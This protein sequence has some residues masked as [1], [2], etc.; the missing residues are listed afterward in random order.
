MTE[1]QDGPPID[2][3]FPLKDRFR[4][5]FI[6]ALLAFVGI[7][8][9]II[10]FTARHAVE[11]IYL[12]LA[13]RRAQSIVRSIEE[14][15]NATWA[16]LMAGRSLT[17]LERNDVATGLTAAF[18]EQVRQQDLEELKV[19]DLNRRVLYATLAEEIGTLEN[20][21]A[22]QQAI[23]ETESGLVK[24]TLQDGTAQYELYVPVF[25]E[26]GTLRA[27]FELYEPVSYLN[28]IL[29]KSAL[30]I[31]SI[32]GILFLVLGIT[33]NKLVTAAQADIDRR[34]NTINALRKRL[35]SFVSTKAVDAVRNIPSN[36]DII[37]KR[38]TETLFF[39]DIRDFT[40]FSEQHEPEE[41]VGF[42]NDIMTL[43]V[44]IL[45]QY[46]GDVDKM[47]GDAILARFD[48]ADSIERAIGA[49]RKIQEAV[50]RRQLPRFLGIGIYRGEMISG[51]IGPPDRRDFTVIG[52]AVNVAARLCAAA[53]AN[54][55]VVEAGLAD[56]GF[57]A[58][59]TVTVKGRE[60]PIAIRRTSVTVP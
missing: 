19:Y 53:A 39:S 32:P 59:E 51:T 40:G 46:G 31:I 7:S 56:A 23:E 45:R 9:L 18:A 58:E 30:P 8:L 26:D 22:L 20:G 60:Q 15:E 37:S 4:R 27:V 13:Q 43:Q 17:E 49:A 29:L 38:V 16:G 42:L 50:A 14:T 10:G 54:E 48:G 34:T 2:E 36:S 24:K 28:G 21:P 47:I 55:I 5:R 57:Q 3:P 11:A 1:S 35:E 25:D 41:V 33:L 12:E 6:P 52:D 44:D